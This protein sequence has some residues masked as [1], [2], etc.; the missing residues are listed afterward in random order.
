MT[1]VFQAGAATD[2]G[3]LRSCNED[4]YWMDAERGVFLVVD[5]V[6]GQAAGERAAQTA[7]DA[8]RESLAGAGTASAEERVREAIAGANNRICGLGEEH[9]ELR[10]MACVLTLALLEEEQITIG[11]VG[12][13]R[14]YLVWKGNIRKLTSDHSPVGE[15]EDA[16]ELSEEEAM[17]HPRRNEVFRDVGS[18][19]RS[20]GDE[21]F[22]EIRTCRF[23]PDAAILLCSDGLTDLLTASEVREIVGRYN[24][25]AAARGGR[26]G[27]SGQSGRGLGQYYGSVRGRSAVSR[28]R[29]HDASAHAYYASAPAAAAVH[30]QDGVSAVRAAAGHGGVGLPERCVVME[31]D[32]WTGREACPT[33]VGRY[34]IV[35]RLGRSMTDVYLAIDTV[36][37]PAGRA[38]AGK[39]RRR[40][41]LAPDHGGRAARRGNPTRGADA[42]C[43]RGGDLRR[44]R[45]G[46]LLLRGH[47]ISWKAATWPKSCV[48]IT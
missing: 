23:H 22:I 13:S 41:R 5:G 10:G 29:R 36:D 7:V 12:D 19:R 31:R 35:R 42:G 32:S 48:R 40:P 20:P 43:A 18:R 16:G 46:R 45:R 8:V 4:R 15:S 6:G 25:D 38:Q 47:A 27:G 34:E 44:G 21:G 14:L 39:D 17:Q 30:R 1:T 28:G 33:R 37:E 9:P 26:V 2:T 24:G 3:L 11:H